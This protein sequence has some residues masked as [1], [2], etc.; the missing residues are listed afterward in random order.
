MTAGVY[1]T[2]Y[3]GSTDIFIAKFSSGLTSLLAA[4]YIGGTG[5]EAAAELSIDT[6]NMIYVVGNTT[7]GSFP[8]TAG[9]FDTSF[10][11]GG[12]DIIVFKMN[13]ALTGM[14]GST[15]VGGTGSDGGGGIVAF[16]QNVYIIG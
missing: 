11:G 5:T 14:L 10:N 16:N 1:D 9:A 15:F 2:G 12:A 6:G 8:T 4:T 7:N 3:S 13:N